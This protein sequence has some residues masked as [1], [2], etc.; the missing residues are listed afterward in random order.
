[1]WMGPFAMAGLNARV[2]GR[3]GS[4][5]PPVSYPPERRVGST[6][7]SLPGGV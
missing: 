4:T 1:M 3:G 7:D 5:P 2:V 6:L